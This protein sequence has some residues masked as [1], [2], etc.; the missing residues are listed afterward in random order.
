MRVRGGFILGCGPEA[1]IKLG[2]GLDHKERGAAQMQ[3][4]LLRREEEAQS[5]EGSQGLSVE[6]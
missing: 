5:A 2:L 1:R 3:N 6:Q 4:F